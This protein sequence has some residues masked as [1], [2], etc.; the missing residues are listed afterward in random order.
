MFGAL[1][2][3][4][5]AQA[6]SGCGEQGLLF[7]VGLGLLTA[8]ASLV[9]ERGLWSSGSSSGDT[10]AVLSCVGAC[11][12]FLDQGSN[13]CALLWQADSQPL[14]HQGSPRRATFDILEI[15]F[16]MDWG[17]VETP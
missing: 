16:V 2:S 10:G 7:T 13:P 12:I 11:G 5:C 4:L 14:D 15:L 1:G 17:L 6:F 9:V 3:L 8:V